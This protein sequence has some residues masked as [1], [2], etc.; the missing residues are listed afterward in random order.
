MDGV[1]IVTRM[2]SRAVFVLFCCGFF[3]LDR[4]RRLSV[5]VR[6]D[7]NCSG[8]RAYDKGLGL[9]SNSLGLTGERVHTRESHNW[10]GRAPP[11]E[12]STVWIAVPV[13]I[14][15]RPFKTF[16]LASSLALTVVALDLP[17]VVPIILRCSLRWI[18]CIRQ[19]EAWT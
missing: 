16:D 11:S 13:G 10:M 5:V 2:Y 3:Y 9:G 8:T 17:G 14:A 19:L 15:P 6:H 4:F 12:A 7:Q 18:H 1:C